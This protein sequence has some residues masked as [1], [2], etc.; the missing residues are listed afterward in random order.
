MNQKLE[1]YTSRFWKTFFGQSILTLYKAFKSY[2][3][4]RYPATSAIHFSFANT[5]VDSVVNGTL[6]LARTS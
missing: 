6:N 1:G 5:A 3:V 2:L 4:Y